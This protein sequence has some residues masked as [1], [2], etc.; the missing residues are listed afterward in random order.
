MS[1]D[2]SNQLIEIYPE[3]FSNIDPRKPIYLFGIECGDGWFELLKEL[4]IE[5][6]AICKKFDLVMCP[7]IFGNEHIPLKV[8]QIKEKYGTLRFYMNWSTQEMDDAI[9][10]AEVKSAVTCEMCGKPGELRQDHYWVYVSCE[11]CKICQ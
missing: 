9:D 4:I 8:I 1:P 2:K 10:R 6:K 5:L 3:L 11:G 7:D